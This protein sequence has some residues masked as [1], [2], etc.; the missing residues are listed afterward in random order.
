MPCQYHLG[1]HLVPGNVQRH[2]AFDDLCLADLYIALWPLET[3]GP[4]RVLQD[5]D[6]A[7]T[8]DHLKTK[9]VDTFMI[10]DNETYIGRTAMHEEAPLYDHN[11]DAR[12]ASSSYLC[13]QHVHFLPLRYEMIDVIQID[14]VSVIAFGK[15]FLLCN[16][17]TT[18]CRTCGTRECHHRNLWE[19]QGAI[20]RLEGG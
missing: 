19:P 5:V 10:A 2:Q 9:V 15:V 12:S 20:T 13:G 17:T 7:P 3:T 4:R 1:I 18:K 14:L 11:H 6:E 16:A 8:R